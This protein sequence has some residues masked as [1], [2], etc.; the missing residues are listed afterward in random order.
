MAR[1]ALPIPAEDFDPTE[2][3]ISWKVLRDLGH[4]VVFATPDGER[5][6]ADQ[7]MLDGVGLDPWGRV[8][9]LRRI[10]LIGLALRANGDARRAYAELMHDRAFRAPMRWGDMAADAFDALVL[11]GGHRARGMRGYLESEALQRLTRAFFAADRPVGAI[12]HGVLLAARSIG[13]DGRSVLHGRRTTALTWR[14]ERLADRIARVARWWEPGYYRTYPEQPGQPAGHMSVEQEVKRAL[15]SPT[16][17]IDVTADT[18]FR[19]RKTSGLH[20]DSSGD[21]RPGFVVVDGHYVSARWPGDAH[22]F[23]TALNCVIQTAQDRMY[24]R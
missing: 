5:G 3:A 2:V 10:R 4:D 15:A 24:G 22:S 6:R 16:D 8:A 14:Q 12:C 13:D 9:G 1:I 20:R 23:A 17:F 19:R 7:T 21:R 18:P 11:T